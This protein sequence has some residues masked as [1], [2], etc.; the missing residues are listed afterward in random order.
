MVDELPEELVVGVDLRAR[1]VTRELV[2]A[3]RGR[4]TKQPGGE[5]LRSVEL[6]EPHARLEE[7]LARGVFRLLPGGEDA[8]AE[9]KDEGRHPVVDP[10]PGLRVALLSA[11]REEGEILV[12]RHP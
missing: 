12:V 9:S 10:C 8:P 4:R 6:G 2:P 11:L 1:P 3:V 7:D 5:G